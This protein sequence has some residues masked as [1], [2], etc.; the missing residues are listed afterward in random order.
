MFAS[1]QRAGRAAARRSE[2]EQYSLTGPDPLPTDAAASSSSRIA[3]SDA[4]SSAAE[5][6]EHDEREERGHAE[7]E[8]EGDVLARRAAT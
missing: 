8:P 6:D 7:R 2:Q 5:Q 4:P 3:C 1:R